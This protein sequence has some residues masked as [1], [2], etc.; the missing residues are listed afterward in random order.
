[1]VVFVPLEGGWRDR[2]G[3]AAQDGRLPQMGRHV[4]HVGD[5]GRVWHRKTREERASIH[6]YT[7]AFTEMSSQV[8]PPHPTTERATLTWINSYIIMHL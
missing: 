4:L 2:H 8:T 1:M 3:F 5:H 6:Q 7:C